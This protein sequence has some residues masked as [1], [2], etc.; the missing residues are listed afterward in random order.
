MIK[1]FNLIC[2]VL[3]IG[4]FSGC[5]SSSSSSGG[6]GGGSSLPPVG[7][8]LDDDSVIRGQAVYEVQ[9]SNETAMIKLLSSFIPKA[10]AATGTST[11][12]YVNAASV[13]FTINVANFGAQGMT[14]NTLNL[15]NVAL[16][17]LDDNHLKVCGVGGNQK[18]LKAI[19]RVYTT[20]SVSGFVN[21]DD[22]TYGAPLYAGTLNPTSPVGLTVSNAV[23]VQ[24]VNIPSNM[25][26]IKLSDFPTPTYAVTSDFS[27][28]GSGTY[29]M[30]FVVEY[31]LS[32]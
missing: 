7:V 30:T 2:L 27:N 5:G 26:R 22:G 20:G 21:T 28:A 10:Y 32:L 23:Q 16:A 18:C 19:I 17:S 4:L 31:A 11:V 13:S 24:V 9:M 29:S 15:G 14:G 25:N 1:F 3:I 8:P 12:T 6:S